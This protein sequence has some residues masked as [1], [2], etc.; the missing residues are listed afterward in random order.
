MREWSYESFLRSCD[1]TEKHLETKQSGIKYNTRFKKDSLGTSLPLIP[2]DTIHELAMLRYYIVHRYHDVYKLVLTRAI[3]HIVQ[4]IQESIQPPNFH[5]KV[6]TSA[7]SVNGR[8]SYELS[9]PCNC[10]QIRAIS[11][12]ECSLENTSSYEYSFILPFTLKC[13][14][15]MSNRCL[16]IVHRS[17]DRNQYPQWSATNIMEWYTFPKTLLPTQRK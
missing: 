15:K 5:N 11:S 3:T 10:S 2:C 13:S 17:F 1:R 4:H 7:N 16:G 6:A 12:D 9:R 14:F 8:F